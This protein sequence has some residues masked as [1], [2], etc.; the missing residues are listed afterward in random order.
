MTVTTDHNSYAPGATVTISGTVTPG[1]SGMLV[2]IIVKDPQSN[3][4]YRTIASTG[5]NGAYSSYFSS[6]LESAQPTGIYTVS[7]YAASAGSTVATN[8]MTYTVTAT[9]TPTP[10]PTPVPATPTPTPVPATPTPTPTPVPATPTPTPVP[11]TPTPAP[12]TS[13]TTTPTNTPTQSPT[14]QP[15]ATPT[16][17][18]IAT[19][20]PQPTPTPTAPEFPFT[21]IAIVAVMAASAA[22]L[23]GFKK[24]H[25]NTIKAF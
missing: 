2:T 17:A 6:I 13:P 18:P 19:S 9:S 10:T 5:A 25:R 21:V 3:E 16:A 15:T 12:T 22:V 4:V 11:A 20:T 1:S 24:T 8:S 14:T 23:L 7:V